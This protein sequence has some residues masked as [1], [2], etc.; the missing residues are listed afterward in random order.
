MAG[1]TG[2]RPS[3]RN[4]LSDAFF[5]EERA[6]A[7]MSKNGVAK[8]PRT[9]CFLNFYDVNIAAGTTVRQDL[10]NPL[11]DATITLQPEAGTSKPRIFAIFAPASLVAVP[12]KPTD[13]VETAIFVGPGLEL[14]RHGLRHAFQ[15]GLSK[16]LIALPG[17]ERVTPMYGFG[18]TQAQLQGLFTA[19]GVVGVPRIRV[20]AGFSTGY[21]GVNGIINNTKSSQNPAAAGT[22]TG[23]NPGLGLDLSGVRKVICFDAFYRGDDPKPGKNLT[24]A[25]AAIHAETGGAAELIVYDVTGAGTPNLSG[26]S[27]PTVPAGMT[28][29]HRDVKSHTNKMMALILARVL[30]NGIKDNFT[31]DAE[32]KKQGGQAVLDLIKNHLVPRGTVGSRP[33][34]G[35]VQVSNWAPD[36]LCNDARTAGF[37]L[38]HNIIG[39]HKLMGWKPPDLFEMLHDG[40]LFELSWE[41]LVP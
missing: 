39:K 41:E 35:T 34:S 19:A 7:H 40:H 15:N 4:L 22:A 32:V 12:G 17:V 20:L 37:A 6:V 2:T 27:A 38:L 9:G 3:P 24:R 11:H 5:D 23:T 33:G 30:D 26:A 25:L 1:T 13:E 28:L 8:N 36:K 14:N 29:S 18:I 31:D 16:V 21:R 10:L